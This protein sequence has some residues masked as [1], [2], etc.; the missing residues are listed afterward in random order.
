MGLTIDGFWDWVTGANS[1]A[2]AQRQLNKE[3]S[4]GTNQAASKQIVILKELS[5]AYGKLGDSV[6]KKKEFLDK[7]SEKIKET[8]LSVNDLKTAEDV[9]INNTDNYINAIVARAKAQATENA[10]IKLYQDYLNERYDLEQKFT[11]RKNKDAGTNSKE[12]YIT[13][14]KGMGMT[15]EQAEEA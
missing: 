15:A 5:I 10:A 7:Y 8:G 12:E 4:E 3:I 2:E 6:D 13:L 1:A 9:F 11:K 14:L